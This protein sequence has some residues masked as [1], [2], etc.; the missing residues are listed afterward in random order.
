M[1]SSVPNKVK[2]FL[3]FFRSAREKHTYTIIHQQNSL[4]NSLKMFKMLVLY[5]KRNGSILSHEGPPPPGFR[6][7]F[8]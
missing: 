4:E 2:F 1:N 3:E 5:K 8:V 6:S 7:N